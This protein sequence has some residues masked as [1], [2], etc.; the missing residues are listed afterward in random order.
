[1][2]YV[3]DKGT[4]IPF[5]HKILKDD[6]YERYVLYTK[7]KKG[8][9]VWLKEHLKTNPLQN[10]EKETMVKYI[11]GLKEQP[12]SVPNIGIGYVSAWFGFSSIY[13]SVT[14]VLVPLLANTTANSYYLS[15]LSQMTTTDS[16]ALDCVGVCSIIYGFRII[17]NEL[18]SPYYH[19]DEMLR[20]CSEPGKSMETGKKLN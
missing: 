8:D 5:A 18:R 13:Y 14:G 10:E 17:T 19:Y 12:Y 2:S 6:E 9:Y 4:E 7:V 1:L 16:I 3:K 20:I 15:F 11:N